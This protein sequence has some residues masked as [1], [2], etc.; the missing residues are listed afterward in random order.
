MCETSEG[1]T[2]VWVGVSNTKG[3][4]GVG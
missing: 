4:G 3:G 1:W 2:F